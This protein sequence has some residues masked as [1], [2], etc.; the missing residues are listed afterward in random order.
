MLTEKDKRAV[1]GL[2][3]VG[4]D[5]SRGILGSVALPAGLDVVLSMKPEGDGDV[6]ISSAKGDGGKARDWA[7]CRAVFRLA[8]ERDSAVIEM[9]QPFRDC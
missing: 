3:H 1:V 2:A 5:V 4:K 9:V 8:H 7:A 6:V